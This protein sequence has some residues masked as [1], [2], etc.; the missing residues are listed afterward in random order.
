M[1]RGKTMNIK[2]W[3]VLLAT[4]SF[5]IVGYF[6]S[7]SIIE[8]I[9]AIT[10]LLCVWFA[11]KE[12]IWTYPVGFINIACFMIVFYEAKLYADFT[13]QIFFAVLSAW[14]WI[15]W[16]TKR[17]GYDVRP[18]TSLN[19]KQLA[20]YSILILIFTAIWGYVLQTYTDASIPYLD[21]FI[22][23]FSVVAQ[24]LLSKKVLQNWYFWIIVDVMSIGMYLYKDLTLIA[25][26]YIMFLANAIYGA[27]KWN[28]SYKNQIQLKEITSHVQSN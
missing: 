5:G 2:T 17:Q 27:I 20:F 16:L 8:I 21:A 24:I 3:Q 19:F 4:I 11:A 25:I 18:T 22:A 26:L 28:G 9:S 14:G 12:N 7:S 15:I 10:G 13:L 1:K 6:T 23:M